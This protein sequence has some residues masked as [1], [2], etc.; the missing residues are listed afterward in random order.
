MSGT[1]C[2]TCLLCQHTLCDF[3]MRSNLQV[4]NTQRVSGVSKD[5]LWHPDVHCS[6]QNS[7]CVKDTNWQNMPRST[8]TQ[9]LRNTTDQHRVVQYQNLVISVVQFILINTGVKIYKGE[10]QIVKS[11]RAIQFNAYHMTLQPILTY[12]KNWG[13]YIVRCDLH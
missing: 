10:Y 6:M 7:R 5:T 4:K 9:E 3:Q 12:L 1:K 11:Y 13:S 8:G 2:A